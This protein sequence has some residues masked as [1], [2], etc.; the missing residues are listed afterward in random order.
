MFDHIE[1]ITL[2][3]DDTLWPCFPTIKAAEQTL[4]DWLAGQAPALV[5]GHSIESLREHRLAVAAEHPH[6]AH[7]L[8]WVRLHSL[9]LLA[10]QHDL[11]ADLA[12][13]A[14]ALFRRERNRVVPYDDVIDALRQLGERYAL[15]A[16]S[17]GN[18]QVE[19]TPL[20]GCFHHSFMAEQ[21]GAAK[22]HPALFEAASEATGVGLQQALHVGDD[23]LRDVE[24]ARLA[25]MATAWV[26]RDKASWPQELAPPQLRIGNLQQLL[27]ALEGRA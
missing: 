9:R 27:H 1:L 11:P 6:K 19:H 15:V 17:N 21:V 12:D 20:A 18:A 22:P 3:L 5:A 24:A 26:N 13:E 8:T 10:R 7:D 2:D 14:N 16:V 25:G 4:F 23:P